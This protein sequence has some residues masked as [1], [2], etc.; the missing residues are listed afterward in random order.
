MNRDKKLKQLRDEYIINEV[1]SSSTITDTVHKLSMR[2]FL[3]E[4]RIY[5]IL[6]VYSPFTETTVSSTE[7]TVVKLDNQ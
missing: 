1:N 7:T 3:S 6:R 2:L 4:R 5:Q